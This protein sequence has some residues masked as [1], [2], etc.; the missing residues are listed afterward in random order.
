MIC[1]QLFWLG[2]LCKSS[3]FLGHT[4]FAQS[5]TKLDDLAS[6]KALM[7]TKSTFGM[8]L[9][10]SLIAYKHWDPRESNIRIGDCVHE[11]CGRH[12][13]TL[14]SQL[15][16]VFDRGKTWIIQI[17]VRYQKLDTSHTTGPS[18]LSKPMLIPGLMIDIRTFQQ[19]NCK[20][21]IENDIWS[22]SMLVQLLLSFS[23]RDSGLSRFKQWSLG[24]KDFILNY[25]C[26]NM[27]LMQIVTRAV[28]LVI[29][30]LEMKKGYA[31]SNALMYAATIL[32][33]ST[34]VITW[35]PGKFNTFMTGVAYQCC[36]RNFLSIYGLLNLVFDRGKNWLKSILVLLMLV[37][38]RGKFWSS[39]IWVQVM[40]DL[41]VFHGLIPMCFSSEL[42][43]RLAARRVIGI[44]SNL[45]DKVVLK[46]WVLIETKYE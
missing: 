18:Q 35:D 32:K 37:Y 31:N 9:W 14:Y 26:T 17:K 33:S 43:G 38:D 27:V 21:S 15:K 8:I 1:V 36:L 13:S 16:F 34:M 42:K 19:K 45:E 5:I 25:Y 6:W 46:G 40:T 7:E 23:I 2:C 28:L 29:K 44:M 22:T 4:F 10:H 39:S 12:F 41:I 24:D 30:F 3:I 11:C 20:W